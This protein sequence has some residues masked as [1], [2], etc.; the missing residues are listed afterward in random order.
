MRFDFSHG[1]KLTSE[2]IK[3]VEKIVNKK[4][5]EDLKVIKTLMKQKEADKKRCNR[6]FSRKI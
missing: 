4:I 1:E 3:E 5:K 2:Q 6:P